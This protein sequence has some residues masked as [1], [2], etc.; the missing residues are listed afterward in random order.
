MRARSQAEQAHP[1]QG[2]ANEAERAARAAQ[3]PARRKARGKIRL[4][5]VFVSGSCRSV[6]VVNRIGYGLTGGWLLGATVLSDSRTLFRVGAGIVAVEDAVRVRVVVRDAAAALSRF[7]LA[8]VLRTEI[9]AVRRAVVIAV[10]VGDAA[11]ADTGRDLLRIVRAIVNAIGGLVLVRV[12]VR[13]IATACAGYVLARISRALVVAVVHSVVVA[14]ALAARAAGRVHRLS[15][16]CTAAEVMLIDHTVAISIR[17]RGRWWRWG[18]FTPRDRRTAACPAGAHV[19][20][21]TGVAVI[22]RCDVRLVV[23]VA[24]VACVVGAWVLIVTVFVTR[25]RIG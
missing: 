8:W 25:A 21:R 6:E 12:R 23:T 15:N 19:V 16:G 7:S 17:R 9:V 5:R 13:V 1:Q 18:I 10:V 2:A 24:R 4:V 22:A 3:W 14:V 20:C 11:P